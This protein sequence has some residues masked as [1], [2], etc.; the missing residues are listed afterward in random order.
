MVITI[1]KARPEDVPVLQV[2]IPESVRALQAEH[3]SAEQMEGALGTV[4]GVDTQLIS[5][6]TYFIA[7]AEGN[8][9]GC[10]GWSR[11]KT[12][13]GS[14]H[15]AGKDDAWLDPGVDAARIRAFFIHPG[16]ARRGI[17]SQILRC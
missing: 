8:I 16:W 17:S 7:E 11:R 6:G 14:D 1:R 4:F 9:V 13:F 5:D 2:L 3:Y 15:V 12:L 10:G